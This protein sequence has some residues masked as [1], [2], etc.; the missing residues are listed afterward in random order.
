[1]GDLASDTQQQNEL[2]MAMSYVT[3]TGVINRYGDKDT[4]KWFDALARTYMLPTAFFAKKWENQYFAWRL[5]NKVPVADPAKPFA[6]AMEELG[7]RQ[8]DF[9]IFSSS[10]PYGKMLD[11]LWSRWGQN[12]KEIDEYFIGLKSQPLS[13]DPIERAVQEQYWEKNPDNVDASWSGNSGVTGHYAMLASPE[14]IQ[15]NKQYKRDGFDGKTLEDR[16]DKAKFWT[17][18][19]TSLKAQEETAKP[20]FFLKLFLT[21]FKNDGFSEA[22]YPKH[23]SWIRTAQ[24]VSALIQQEKDVTFDVPKD[25]T[26]EPDSL[27]IPEDEKKNQIK[28]NAGK[29]VGREADLILEYLFQGT[30]LQANKVPPPKE[31]ADVLRFFVQYF[32]KHLN[33]LDDAT[34]AAAFGAEEVHHPNSNPITLIPRAEYNKYTQKNNVENFGKNNKN[35]TEEEKRKFSLYQSDNLFLNRQMTELERGLRGLMLTHSSLTGL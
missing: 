6:E 12:A 16:Q 3:L 20:D 29:Y 1:M 28:I 35:R 27:P 21:R 11:G 7:L 23:I 4:R 34:L 9:T 10:V 26:K 33:D 31:F 14:V 32:K 8:S 19:L 17:T 15:Q 25:G 24:S 30:V 13:S 18:L 5:L 22:S 2:K